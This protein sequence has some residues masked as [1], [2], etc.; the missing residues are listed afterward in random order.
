MYQRIDHRIRKSKKIASRIIEGNT[1]VV[2]PEK[3]ALYKFNKVGTYIWKCISNDIRVK[4]IV[5][6][7]C[8]KYDVSEKR[9]EKDVK[10]F[11][12]DLVKKNI[13]EYVD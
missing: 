5:R 13:L 11:I 6:K 9:A 3:R 10:N 2:I 4:C 1:Y 7:V 8:K 12:K